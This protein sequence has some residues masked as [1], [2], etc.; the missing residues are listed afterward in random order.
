MGMSV[1]LVSGSC[2]VA[3]TVTRILEIYDLSRENFGMPA[4]VVIWW[5]LT[6][7]CCLLI[8]SPLTEGFSAYNK[9]VLVC[10]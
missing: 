8:L 7:T 1:I 9:C 3:H 6:N 5:T 10:Y 4:V 2:Q